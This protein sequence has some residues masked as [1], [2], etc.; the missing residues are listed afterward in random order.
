MELLY[1]NNNA[2]NRIKDEIRH[3]SLERGG[4]GMVILHDLMIASSLRRNMILLNKHIH[5][6]SDLQ[7]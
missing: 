7:E 3:T 4:F 6:I 1:S 5:P 2:P